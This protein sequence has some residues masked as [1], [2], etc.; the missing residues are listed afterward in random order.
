MRTNKEPLSKIFGKALKKH[1]KDAHMTQAQFA[2]E[3]G[4]VNDEV[5]RRWISNGIA[6]L[7][8]VDRI[9]DFFNMDLEEFLKK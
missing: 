9:L 8:T 4:Y 3:M 5:I 1:I 7:D 6:K 2:E